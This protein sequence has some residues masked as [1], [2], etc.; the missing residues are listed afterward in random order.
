VRPQ[1]RIVGDTAILSYDL[2]ETEVVFGQSMHARYH[3]TDTWL[4]RN[5]EWRIVAGQVFRYY[6]DPAPGDADVAKYKDY[7]GE[8]ELAKGVE[9]AISV[10]GDKLYRQR[11]GKNREEMIPEAPDIFFRKGVEGRLLFRRAKSGRVVALVDRR[12]NEDIV[13]TKTQ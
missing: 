10:E 1:S 13:W 5:G 7:A 4:R 3:E 8:Y 9:L 11:A 2:D 6:E 12:N